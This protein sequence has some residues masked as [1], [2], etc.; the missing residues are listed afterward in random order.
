MLSNIGKR[1]NNKTNSTAKLMIKMA[2]DRFK[3]PYRY[4]MTKINIF[5]YKKWQQDGS[6]NIL[7]KLFPIKS[8]IGELKPAFR[9]EQFKISRLHICLI[10]L[11]RSFLLKRGNQSE[12]IAS[13]TLYTVK[14]IL[15]E[16]S[17]FDVIRKCFYSTN[18]IRGTFK[19]ISIENVL[20]T[21]RNTLPY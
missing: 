9:K 20:F 8:N 21:E 10:R 16:C 4:L 3:I 14:Y 5:F 7:N 19:N 1:G 12:C 6:N 13:Q 15:I 18:N 17:D 11:K 2:P